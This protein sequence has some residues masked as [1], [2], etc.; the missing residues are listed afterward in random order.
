[1]LHTNR[2][3]RTFGKVKIG[4]DPEFLLFNKYDE[5]VSADEI[6]DRGSYTSEV[7][8]DQDCETGELRPPAGTPSEMMRTFTR[9]LRELHKEVKGNKL[10]V[11][12]GAGR[13]FPDEDGDNYTISLGGHIHFNLHNS[14]RVLSEILDDFIGKPM[15]KMANSDR[16]R[17]GSYGRLTDYETK[18]YG[19]EYRTPPSFIGKPDLFAGVIAVAYCIAKTWVRY[20]KIRGNVWQYNDVPTIQD[21]QALVSYKTYT[22]QID[23]FLSY[24]NEGKSIEETDVLAAWEIARPHEL[25]VRL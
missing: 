14:A 5:F 16:K 12:A 10:S 22:E 20:R 6:L 1:M 21:Y 18:P 2:T 23:T 8:I 13:K 25:T 7:G 3:A 15:L 11:F 9:L 4:L 24:V 19:F 17:F